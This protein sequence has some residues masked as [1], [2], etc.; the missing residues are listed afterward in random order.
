MFTRILI[1]NRGEIACRVIKT[2]KRLGIETVAVYST[3]DEKAEHVKAADFAFCIGQPPASASYLNIE[4]IIKVAL[5]SGAQAIHPGYG[6]LSENPAFAKACEEN[7]IV[8]IGPSIQAMEAMASKQVAKQL[9]EKTAVP[10]T[11]GYHGS[12]QTD[13][14]LLKEAKAIGFPVLLKAASGGGGKGMRAVE[15][16]ADFSSALEGARREAKA[17]FSDDTLIIEKLIRHPR[18]VEIQIMADNHGEVVH[19]FERDCSIQRRH[20][21]IIE[22]APAP[23]L[24]ATL[25]KNLAKSACEVAKSINYR[26]AGTVEFLVGENDA[27]YFM[28]MN[29][30]LQVEH[31]VTEMITGLDLVEWQLAIAAGEPLPCRQADI[32]AHGHAIECRVYAEDPY[33]QFIPSIGQISYLKEPEMEG[34]RIDSGVKQGSEISQYYDPM[35]SKLIAWGSHREQAIQ[36]MQQALSHYYIAGVKS[37]IPFLKSLVKNKAFVQAD[38]STEFLNQQRIELQPLETLNALKLA[39]AYDYLSRFRKTSDPLFRDCFAWQSTLNRHWY[40]GYTLDHQRHEVKITA[41]N[42]EE[43]ILSYQDNNYPCKAEMKDK[44]L[45]LIDAKT[46]LQ[47]HID[48]QQDQLTIFCEEGQISLKRFSWDSLD[49]KTG[50]QKGQLTSPMPATVVAI[51]KKIGEP[52]KAGDRLIVLEAMK[53]EH[54]IHAPSNGVLKKLFYNVGA[55]VNEGA[56]LLS[57]EE[58][59]QSE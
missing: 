34:V 6:F 38:L 4:A 44:Q 18:H 13:K 43:F 31:P 32:K 59:P 11:P 35:I 16:E 22:E 37:N 21:K 10:L 7:H 17:S 19:L 47:A 23:H 9:L 2:A 57:L 20:Q 27:Y 30:R 54:T 25:R 8:F 53:M 3:A 52:V 14:Q 1:A 48:A 51:L 55:Q 40:W 5:E 49:A 29:T 45:E 12:Q 42:A 28:E 39:A 58:E 41:V 26:G 36:R 33:Q 46:R 15:K 24:S 56:E 50:Q